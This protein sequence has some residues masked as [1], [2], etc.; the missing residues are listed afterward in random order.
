MDLK[1]CQ[2][3]FDCKSKQL[4][5]TLKTK[6]MKRSILFTALFAFFICGIASA[7]DNIILVK[8][9]PP[10]PFPMRMETVLP[11]SATI[12]ASQLAI[13]F[14]PTVGDATITV[15]DANNNV[16]YQETVDTDSNSNVYISSSSWS[17]GSYTVVIS[18]G[19]TTVRG[20]FDME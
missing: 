14:E 13:Y 1:N 15:Y 10:P 2:H 20:Y 17:A 16:V 3:N 5:L 6:L 9:P 4:V 12:D 19:T 8:D 11:V 7:T 18:Y